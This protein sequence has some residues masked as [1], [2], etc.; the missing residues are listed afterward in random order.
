MKKSI[1]Y[2]L[3]MA[4]VLLLS[5]QNE[6][7]FNIDH[8]QSPLKAKFEANKTRVFIDEEVQFTNSSI[9][10]KAYE[11]SFEG[12]TP[13]T[14]ADESPVVSY[15][16]EG[17]YKVVLTV[18]DGAKQNVLT[19]ESF[20]TVYGDECW[21]DMV[22]PT[23]NFKNTSADKTLYE[24]IV[25]DPQKLIHT[26]CFDVA[27]WLFICPDEM[28]VLQTINYSVEDKDGISAKGGQ[29]PHIS[30]FFSATY[31]QSCKDK[32]MTDAQLLDEVKGVLYHEVTH[33]YQ[34]SPQGAGEY[35]PGDDFYGFIEGMADYVRYVSGYLTTSDR[36]QGGH[37][38]DGYKT[39]GFFID[40]LHSKDA[41]FLNK[42]NHSAKSINPWSWE[43][44]TQS[45]TGKSVQ[46]LWEEYQDDMKTGK[47]AEIDELLKRLRAGE[48]VDFGVEDPAPATLI[49]ITDQ[50]PT[51][52][53]QAEEF[54][55]FEWGT[56]EMAFD[57]DPGSSFFNMNNTTWY[58]FETAKSYN[59]T[60]VAITATANLLGIDYVFTPDE[61]VV[62]G[63]NDGTEWTEITK[64]ENTGIVSFEERKE[65]TFEN[66]TFYKFHKIT[67]AADIEEGDNKRIM[68]AEL[69]L[70]G[71]EVEGGETPQANLTDITKDN[72]T[73]TV[74][75]AGDQAYPEWGLPEHAYDGKQDTQFFNWVNDTWLAFETA[76]KYNVTKV[77]LSASNN[78]FGIEYVFSA[79][80]F[81][82]LGS[83]DGTN[84]TEI[85]KVADTGITAFQQKEEFIFENTAY[86]RYHKIELTADV[87]ENGRIVIG[88]LEIWGVA[89]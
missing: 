46:V 39:S 78:I 65:F 23:I 76:K 55:F 89:E 8:L 69:E 49:D 80:E 79:D 13:S 12:G 28:D 35:K 64:V 30:I 26:A 61:F 42:L 58:T 48:D 15:A 84:W 52:S 45:I 4:L 17:T 66:A 9:G 11:W 75:P 83:D 47:I 73:V 68:I 1:I 19:Q 81:T 33:G 44:A 53:Y 72:P 16:S 41:N 54:D 21:Q 3:M 25:P 51:V 57:N 77:A 34:F 22:M 10:A 74:K 82:L 31:L 50:N 70:F 88:E 40:W 71:A 43:A 56:P 20:I 59:V 85:T 38:N 37:W 60:K 67:L 29:A 63:S 32:G 36:G 86:Y 27:R 24:Q 7:E 5:C 87:E 6:A 2:T 62:S 18:K 14:S